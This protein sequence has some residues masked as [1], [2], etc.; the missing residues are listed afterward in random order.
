MA[1][2]ALNLNGNTITKTLGDGTAKS[3][4]YN[5]DDQVTEINETLSGT[6]FAKFD[7]GYDNLNR[8]TY[9]QRNGT[10]GDVYSY[11][12]VSQVTN[13]AYDA[14]APASSSSGADRTVAYSLDSNGNRTSVNDST[15]S[16]ATSYTPNNLNQ[17]TSVGGIS[18]GYDGNGK[19]A[20]D[21]ANEDI[22]YDRAKVNGAKAYW[23][24]MKTN[25][26]DC[27]ARNAGIPCSCPCQ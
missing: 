6:S 22:V 26:E 19:D 13:V 3:H 27:M 8:R 9:E 5:L 15:L 12:Y 10:T 4:L 23:E 18:Y 17:Y 25:Y 7:Y 11:D 24:M 21:V 14:T 20:R 16:G 1:S 2:Y